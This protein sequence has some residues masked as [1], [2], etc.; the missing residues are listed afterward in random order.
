[1]GCQSSQYV[2]VL[3]VC[4]CVNVNHKSDLTPKWGANHSDAAV[5]RGAA[6]AKVRQLYS[7]VFCQQYV[8]TCV[9]RK[10]RNK[11]SKTPRRHMQVTLCGNKQMIEVVYQGRTN[12]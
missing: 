5:K 4:K 3:C 8:R 12:K 10:K 11:L 9:R 6:A 1:M 2:C 7:A